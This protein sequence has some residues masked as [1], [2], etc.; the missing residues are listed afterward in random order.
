[1]T[2]LEISQRI[3]TDLDEDVSTPTTGLVAEVLA[4]IEEGIQLAALLTLYPEKTA[5]LPLSAGVCWLTPRATLTDMIV[6]LR[7]RVGSA[8]LRPGT[9]GALEAADPRWQALAGTPVRYTSLGSNLLAITP[10]PAALSSASVTYAYSPA[11]LSGDSSVPV[12][13]EQYHQNLVD[14]GYYRVRLKE[15]AQGLERGLKR[16]NTFLDGMQELGDYVRARSRAARYDVLPYEL[17]GFDR[18]RMI[19]EVLKWQQKN[20]VRA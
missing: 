8:R 7:I 10:Q 13:P 11:A 9:L 1:M 14:Y 6:P 15:G 17:A 18:S 16:L 19:E 20:Q 12:I 2:R 3:Q 5:N 4:A